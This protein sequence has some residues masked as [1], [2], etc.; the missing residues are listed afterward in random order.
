MYRRTALCRGMA[1]YI[2]KSESLWFAKTPYD[3]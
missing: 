3:D 2:G 1:N